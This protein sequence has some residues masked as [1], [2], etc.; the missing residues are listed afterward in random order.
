[1]NEN[2]LLFLAFGLFLNSNVSNGTYSISIVLHMKIV[3]SY[4][5]SLIQKNKNEAL[6]ISFFFY[7]FKQKSLMTR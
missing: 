5:G 3:V 2:I 1:M 4:F 6:N 7:I